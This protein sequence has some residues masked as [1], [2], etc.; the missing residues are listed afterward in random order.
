[1]ARKKYNPFDHASHNLKTH[2]FL[3][4]SG[5]FPDWE[6]T[7]AFYTSLKFIEGALFPHEYKHPNTE[8]ITEFQTYNKY[9]ST[10]GRFKSGSPHDVMK[11]FV[12][13][14]LDEN[15]WIS[16]EDLYS[17]CHSSRY[18]NYNVEVEELK[19]AAEAL[20]EIRTYCIAN[21]K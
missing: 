7:T 13:K 5:D 2:N 21:Q 14:N 12:K 11:F 16:Y 8:E 9:K 15:I 17:I 3:K 1:M 6:I 20:E 4:E 10:Y 19:I 18:K